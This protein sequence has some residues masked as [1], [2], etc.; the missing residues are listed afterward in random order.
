MDLNNSKHP[1]RRHS[2]PCFSTSAATCPPLPSGGEGWGEGSSTGCTNLIFPKQK[3]H[4]HP[5]LPPPDGG[6]TKVADKSKRSSEN[7]DFRFQT[8]LFNGFK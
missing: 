1:T 7:K 6:R 2:L 4:P 5:N 8:T 3:S